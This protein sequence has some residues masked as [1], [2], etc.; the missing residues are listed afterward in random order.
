[1]AHK[2]VVTPRDGICLCMDAP[3]SATAEPAVITS[4]SRSSTGRPATS[5]ERA[6][7]WRCFRHALMPH[8]DTAQPLNGPCAG[9]FVKVE[10]LLAHG[11]FLHHGRDA[12]G[13]SVATIRRFTGRDKA[14]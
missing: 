5:W 13:L 7:S 4:T 8:F 11:G 12:K 3:K 10:D 1:M 2:R 9:V 6:A 14:T